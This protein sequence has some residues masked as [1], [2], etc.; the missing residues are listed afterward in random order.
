MIY[1]KLCYSVGSSN[2]YHKGLIRTLHGV[3]KRPSLTT[4]IPVARLIRKHGRLKEFL[5]ICDEYQNL[6]YWSF[7][8]WYFLQ[9]TPSWKDGAW[10]HD[11]HPQT[12]ASGRRYFSRKY[13]SGDELVTVSNLNYFCVPCRF[14]AASIATKT[15]AVS[16]CIRSIQISI[17]CPILKKN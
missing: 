6:V 10:C 16:K 3:I 8:C 5:C 14:L 11:T 17:P 7:L 1:F 4:I 12:K 13:R 2:T 9:T 15:R